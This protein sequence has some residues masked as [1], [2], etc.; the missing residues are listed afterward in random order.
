MPGRQMSHRHAAPS[1]PRPDSPDSPDSPGTLGRSSG[2]LAL[3]AVCLGFFM[4]LMDSSALNVALPDIREDLTGS[5]AGLEWVLNGY[6]ITLAAFL[7]SGGSV[8]DRWGPRRV[9][10]ISLLG[11]VVTSA[12]CAVSPGLGFLIAAR[13]LQGITAGGLLPASLAVIA[14]LYT[15][16]ARRAKAL[17]V[18][19][20]VSSLALVFGPVAGGA[21]TTAVGWRAIFLINVPVGLLAWALTRARVAPAPGHDAALDPAGQLLAVLV[22]G[23]GIGALIEGGS[24]GWGDPVTLT[25]LVVTLAAGIAFG[26]VERR[27]AAPVL[28]LGL[29]ARPRFS[30]GLAIGALFQF[31]AYG[32]QFALSLHLQNAWGLDA[33]GAGLSFVPFATLWAFASFVLARAVT[34][35][36][37]RPLLIGGALAAAAGACALLPLGGHPTWWVF[38]AGSGLLGLGAGLMGPSLPAVVMGALPPDR[39]G[40]ASGALN[41]LRQI[42]GAVAIALFGVVLEGSSAVGGLRICLALVA[43]GFLVAVAAVTVSLRPAA[44]APP[45]PAS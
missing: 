38:F 14:R 25:L 28:P 41:A 17:T 27:A 45:A 9:F 18:W 7:L 32:A 33:L 4:V 19:G 21:L 24:R 12:A 31:G 13:A 5:L 26:L 11:F 22:V 43:G 35:T 34:R 30:Y 20:G 15:D 40:L 23:A 3:F 37:P 44:T 2:G 6:T 42:G 1:R 8:S 29:F 36:G 16:P 39:S 10:E